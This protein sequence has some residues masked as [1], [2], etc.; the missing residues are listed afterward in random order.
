MESV[1]LFGGWGGGGGGVVSLKRPVLESVSSFGG[2][3]VSVK[4]PVLETV[5]S[6][7]GGGGGGEGGSLSSSPR[8]R[9]CQVFRLVGSLS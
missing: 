7:V 8:A 2:R 6:F 4:V 5:S 9:V 1:G 3:G